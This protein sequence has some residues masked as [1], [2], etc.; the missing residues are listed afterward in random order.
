MIWLR[1]SSVISS[2]PKPAI[3]P[4]ALKSHAFSESPMKSRI[5]GSAAQARRSAARVNSSGTPEARKARI[6]VSAEIV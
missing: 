6:S 4:G 2:G 1:N 3:A 5:F